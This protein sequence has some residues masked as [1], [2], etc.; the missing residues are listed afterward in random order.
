[1]LTGALPACVALAQEARPAFKIGGLDFGIETFS[2]HDLPP[3]GD[4]SSFG[5]HCCRLSAPRS[6]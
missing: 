1:M 6:F 5:R 3:A 2:F 4:Q